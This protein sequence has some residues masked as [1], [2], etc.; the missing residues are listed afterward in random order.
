MQG[1]IIFAQD[2]LGN[3]YTFNPKDGATHYICRS[4]PEVG[5]VAGS[6]TEFVEELERRDYRIYDWIEEL[7]VRPYDW[8]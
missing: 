1:H 8:S 6:F 7:A 5:F 4:A 3:F 2:G